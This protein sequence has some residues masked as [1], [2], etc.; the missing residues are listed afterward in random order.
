MHSACF[1]ISG[2]TLKPCLSILT[3]PGEPSVL[4]LSFD[5]HDR[6]GY[7]LPKNH[8]PMVLPLRSVGFLMPVSARQVFSCPDF[9]NGWEMFTTGTPFTPFTTAYIF[10]PLS[11]QSPP[12]P[13]SPTP[14]TSHI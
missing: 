14:A 9:L 3:P 6:N 12:H 8:T 5:I 4:S 1:W 13:S 10:T 2:S 7:S 11:Q